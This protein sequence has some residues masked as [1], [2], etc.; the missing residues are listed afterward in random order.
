M[1]YLVNLVNFFKKLF[2]NN[3]PLVCGG[4]GEIEFYREGVAVGS[5]LYRRPK[6]EEILAYE[7]DYAEGFGN[8]TQLKQVKDNK[9]KIKKIQEILIKDLFFPNAEKIFIGSKNIRNENNKIIDNLSKKKQFEIIK[10]YHGYIL[11][12]MVAI[13]FKIDTVSKKKH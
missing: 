8:E 2:G 10:E 6:Y 3:S 12:D 1:H 5:V 7:Y 9:R 11:V 4:T 13:V